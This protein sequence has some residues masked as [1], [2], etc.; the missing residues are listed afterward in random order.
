M[1]EEVR[2]KNEE[3]NDGPVRVFYVERG[4]EDEKWFCNGCRHQLFKR[5]KKCPYCKR[6]L[7]WGL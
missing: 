4:T 6:S 1:N 2:M 7:I 3:G 5:W